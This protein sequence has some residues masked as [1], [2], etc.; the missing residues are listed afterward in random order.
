MNNSFEQLDQLISPL[1]LKQKTL[2]QLTRRS[3][4]RSKSLPITQNSYR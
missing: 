4:I 1:A 3:D 2:N